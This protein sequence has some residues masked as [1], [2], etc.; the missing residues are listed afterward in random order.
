MSKQRQTKRKNKSMGGKGSLT[1]N[2]VDL[3]GGFA[4]RS[5]VK[6]RYVTFV[7]L[8]S[9]TVG[10]ASYTFRG[11]GLFDPDFTSTGLQ[12][13][14]FDDFSAVYLRYRCFGSTFTVIPTIDAVSV[15]GIRVCVAPRHVTTAV[16]TQTLMMDRIS[17]P[18]AQ[19]KHV[20]FNAPNFGSSSSPIFV[21][22]MNTQRF[23]GLSDVEFKGND[24]LTALVTADP[25]HTWYW[26][27]SQ[28]N[29]DVS[30][31]ITGYYTVF[32]DYDVEFWD[33]VDTAL[34]L[35]SQ[36]ARLQF[37]KKREHERKETIDAPLALTPASL[38]TKK[39]HGGK[40]L[41]V[42]K[43]TEKKKREIIVVEDD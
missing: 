15:P 31:T 17:Q 32:I 20:V 23:L 30:D 37:Q 35:D 6:L 18:Y 4:D 42:P 24:D 40:E 21:Q 1:Y 10:G 3:R 9:T 41:L 33:R 16:T 11:N 26:T 38:G 12:P 39:P 13:A 8:T 25:A 2:K 43:P 7:S 34:D 22:H 14:N 5:R 27:I 28:T 36:I 29:I 19:L